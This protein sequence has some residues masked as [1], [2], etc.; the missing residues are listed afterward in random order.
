MVNQTIAG[1]ACGKPIRGNIAFL[2]GPLSFWP[3]LRKRFIETL[4]LTEE[5][6]IIPENSQLFVAMGAAFASCN[7]PLFAFDDIQRAA[8]TMLDA[9]DQEVSPPRASF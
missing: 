4:H 5:Q 2:G 3:Q 6:V 8:N 1:L 9:I 7:G